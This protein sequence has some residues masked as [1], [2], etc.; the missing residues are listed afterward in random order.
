VYRGKRWD[1]ETTDV[2]EF[3]GK[4]GMLAADD[5]GNGPPRP[6]SPQLWHERVG[7]LLHEEMRELDEAIAA[8][9]VV[10]QVDA[11]VDIDYLIKG[12]GVL[13][14]LPWED[15]WD[16]VHRTN[17]AKEPAATVRARRGAV[18]PPGWTPPDLDRILRNYGWHEGAPE[19]DG[20]PPNH[21]IDEVEG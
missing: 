5:S 11:L 9:D 19:F 15:L 8:R 21:V 7:N 14:R 10:A 12:I 16:E 18:K 2:F 13:M 1:E 17:L 6:L 20:P 4:M 3:M